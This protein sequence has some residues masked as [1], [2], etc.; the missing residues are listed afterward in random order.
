MR[1]SRSIAGVFSV[2]LAVWALSSCGGG[3]DTT[4]TPNTTTGS[5]AGKVVDTDSANGG[6]AGASVELSSSVGASRSVTTSAN[7]QFTAGGLEPGTWT[8]LLSTPAGRTLAAG[9]TGERT[10][11]VVAGTSATTLTDFKLARQKGSV[12]GAVKNGTTGV[13]AATLTLARAGF[14]ARSIT[15][16]ASGNFAASQVPTGTWTLSVSVPT[17]LELAAGETGTRSVAIAANQTTQASAFALTTRV[18]PNIQEIEIFG[19]SFSPA[20]LTISAGTTVRWRND[21]GVHTITPQDAS[22]AGGFSRR[23][24][25][26]NGIVLEHVFGVAGQVYRYRCEFHSESFTVGMVGTITVQ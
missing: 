8:V 15:A 24:F 22:Q 11:T 13:G 26:Q 4:G 21:G 19:S 18:V 20:N 17:T 23:E 16:D 12:S 5:I 2:A 1:V 25:S 7:G 10:A 14:P 6:V 9:E 3:G